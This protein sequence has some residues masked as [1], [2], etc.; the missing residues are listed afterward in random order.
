M[1]NIYVVE[2]KKAEFGS[3]KY[4][5]QLCAYNMDIETISQNEVN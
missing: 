2:Q 1:K 3:R 4:S 5:Q